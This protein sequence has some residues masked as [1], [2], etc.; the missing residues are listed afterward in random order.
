VT[1]RILSFAHPRRFVVGTV[2]QP[3]DRTFFLQVT[4]GGAPVAGATVAIDS[5]AL[6]GTRALTTGADGRF[7]FD[8][9]PEGSYRLWAWRGDRAARAVRV[10]RLGRGPF[11]D[12]TLALAPAAAVDR[13][14]VTGSLHGARDAV[15]AA[16]VMGT[17][18]EIRK[19]AGQ[20]VRKGEVL[21]VLD[22]REV[23]GNIGQAEGAL[24]QA[25]AAASLAEANLHRFEQLKERG[26]A[27]QLELDQA[28]YQHETAQGA[29][30]QAEGAVATAGSYP[31]NR[32]D[33]YVEQSP[34]FHA[35]RITTPL[36][37]L[38]GAADTNV[39]VGESEQLY[40]ALRVL[41]KPVEFIKVDGQNHWILNY[42]QRVVWMETI[43]AWFDRQLKGEPG[44]WDEL[45]G[46]G[47]P[48]GD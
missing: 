29:V 26:A 15:L 46:E 9:L 18:V 1:R 22:D 30:R 40:T 45:Y 8:A 21:V 3:G 24:A 25:R 27:S 35:D 11:A 17:V 12:V 42:P 38:H 4:D 34:L 10:P 13:V 37:L 41:G 20:A 48:G 28:R 16:K 44:W 31:W 19:G 7:A 32:P 23:R 5:D 36:L 2:G 14:E 6:F 39:T 47:A 43:I 33:L